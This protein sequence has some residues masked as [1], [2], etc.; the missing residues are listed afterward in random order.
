MINQTVEHHCT[1]ESIDRYIESEL[2]LLDE[3]CQSS[4]SS[5]FY[6]GKA[7]A[8]ISIRNFIH[9]GRPSDPSTEELINNLD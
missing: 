7:Q 3:L 9:N 2:I 1:V 6:N 5:M 4:Y 8:L